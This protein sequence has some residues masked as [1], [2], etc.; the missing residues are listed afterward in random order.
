[1]EVEDCWLGL[2][3]PKKTIREFT[4]A[5][6]NSKTILWNGPMGDLRWKSSQKEPLHRKGD[7]RGYRKKV[8]Q[9]Y[10]RW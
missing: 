4:A 7:S 5:I 3:L 8:P 10:R 1:M 9:P 2:E 6:A